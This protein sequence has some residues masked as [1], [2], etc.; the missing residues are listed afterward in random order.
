[1]KFRVNCQELTSAVNTVARAIP[2]RPIKPIMA[3]I[4]LAATDDGLTL[5]TTDGSWSIR[6]Q[7]AAEVAE[8]GRV[9]LPG[10][11]FT[12][13]CHKLPGGEVNFDV[14]DTRQ[15]TIRCM[16]ARFTLTGLNAMEF[17][18]MNHLDPDES[19][20]VVMPQ[21]KLSDMISHV[22]FA[23]AQDETRQIL[24]G[25]LLEVTTEEARLVALDGYRLAMQ[26]MKQAFTLPEGRASYKAVI[27]GR[28]MLELSRVMNDEDGICS[29]T[30]DGRRMQAV[31]GGTTMNS[32]LLSGEYLDYR[33]IIP[34]D[35]KT[36]VKAE[37]SGVY[38]AIDS[39]SVMANA[40][41]NNIIRMS[42]TED[43]LSITSKADEGD[44]FDSVP[45]AVLGDPLEIAFNAKYISD[46]IRNISES[47]LCM[48]FNS[49]VSPCVFMPVE[50]DSYVY[51]ILPVRVFQ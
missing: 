23:I 43:V 29:L 2:A 41:K 44:V 46:V 7:I 3:G 11:L 32:I 31:F 42:I 40:G 17:P 13:I 26:S 15:T 1:M 4:L 48:K 16:S 22:V 14:K 25:C 10:K 21:T 12:D 51:L 34:T 38:N 49:H 19:V 35:F 24:T 45:C 37:K 36:V 27:P 20:T 9:V 39:A 50:G 6:C 47:E 18:E 33:K 30:F 28:V 8:N 5:S